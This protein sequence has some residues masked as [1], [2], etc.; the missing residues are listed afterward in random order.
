MRWIDA[1]SLR[2]QEFEGLRWQPSVV[3]SGRSSGFPCYRL[4]LPRGWTGY[5][6]G[7]SGL[8]LILAGDGMAGRSRWMD[9]GIDSDTD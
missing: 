2:Q 6:L 1:A 5:N 4:A 3:V 9:I 8:V 7:Y